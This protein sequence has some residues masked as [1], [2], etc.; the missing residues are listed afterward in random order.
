MSVGNSTSLIGSYDSV[1]SFPLTSLPG[2]R[3]LSLSSV[4][5]TLLLVCL[6]PLH[7]VSR[8]IL[9]P[10]VLF[11]VERGLEWVVLA[12]RHQHKLLT[13]LCSTSCFTVSI[14]FYI[15]FIPAVIW[16]CLGST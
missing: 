6:P 1:G 14:A 8:S 12:Q 11:H 13:A 15:T 10:W 5:L 4:T 16:V 3:V 7:S 2:F 9:R